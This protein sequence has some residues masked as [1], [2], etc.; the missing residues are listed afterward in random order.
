MPVLKISLKMVFIYLSGKTFLVN[1]AQAI[2]VT[3]AEDTRT[4][5]LSSVRWI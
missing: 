3:T 2:N 1:R 5:T 4:H